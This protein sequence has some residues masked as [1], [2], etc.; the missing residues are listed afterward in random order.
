MLPAMPLLC[1]AKLFT[2]LL[3]LQACARFGLPLDQTLADML[4]APLRQDLPDCVLPTTLAQLL[5][6]THGLGGTMVEHASFAHDGYLDLTPGIAAV[7]H[8][9]ILHPPGRHYGYG[10]L[11]YLVLGHLLERLYHQRYADIV[12]EHLLAPLA[13]PVLPPLSLSLPACPA[14][15][16]GLAVPLPWVTTLCQ[17]LLQD[18]LAT[19]GID[20]RLFRQITRH[21]AP[22]P[23]WSMQIE[24]SCLGWRHF[25]QQWYG[26]NG[27]DG[28]SLFW[29][30][31]NPER[32][33]A[34]CLMAHTGT[35][36]PGLLP[37]CLFAQHYR[38]LA[39]NPA[40][41]PAID[42]GFH[43]QA[44]LALL[45]HYGSPCRDYH[46][47]AHE[48]R[49]MLEI[50]CATN[51]SARVPKYRTWLYPAQHGLFYLARP[52]RR[53]VFVQLIPEPHTAEFAL[54]DHD[55]LWP[56]QPHGRTV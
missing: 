39:L 36:N 29:L 31:L 51:D 37:A 6:H 35:G 9:G 34:L 26:H 3:V 20:Y 11:G 2:S 1:G 12:R 10:V 54:W 47:F 23:G 7:A 15:G 19:T 32:G 13:T 4:P 22:L 55:C 49:V 18:S 16:R 25:G 33:L 46:L 50:S 5:A 48:G 53:V 28:G 17:H 14:S 38:E 52:W 42:P 40:N 43:L 45:G 24:A 8:E 41:Q 44:N 27:L 30:R 56:K 21:P